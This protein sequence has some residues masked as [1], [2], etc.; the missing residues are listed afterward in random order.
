MEK[1]LEILEEINE[2]LA[3]IESNINCLRDETKGIQKNCVKMAHHV[4]FVQDTY[5]VVRSPLNY[6][7]DKIEFLM[8]SNTNIDLLKIT[9]D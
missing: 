7:K 2:R 6:I 1:L 8:G 9:Y 5:E 3:K 4:D